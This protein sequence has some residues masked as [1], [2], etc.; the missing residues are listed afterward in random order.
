MHDI[1]PRVLNKSKASTSAID[2]IPDVINKNNSTVTVCGSTAVN[3]INGSSSSTLVIN[4]N[5]S[6]SELGLTSPKNNNAEGEYITL[7]KLLGG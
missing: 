2:I 1:S 5:I 7:F 3:N 6:E 4:R